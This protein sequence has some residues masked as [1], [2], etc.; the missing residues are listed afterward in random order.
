MPDL[1]YSAIVAA[2]LAAFI[3]SSGWY[4]A[5]GGQR[6]EVSGMS[7]DGSPGARPP[8]CKLLVEVA[9]SL[10]VAFVLGGLANLLGISQWTDAV[11]LAVSLWIGFPVVLLIGSV[12]WENVSWKLAAIH[13]GDWLLKLL[14]IAV[15]VG[16]W[17]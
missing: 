7:P 6:A 13:A 10:I 4:V 16:G 3:L 12:I 5:F 17:R 8:G 15:I 1:N 2:A 11:R 9:R 14:V